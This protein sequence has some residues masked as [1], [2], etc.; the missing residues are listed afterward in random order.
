MFLRFFGCSGSKTTGTLEATMCDDIDENKKVNGV[1]ISPSD[2]EDLYEIDKLKK[3][4]EKYTNY[5]IG[6]TANSLIKRNT[7]PSSD[8]KFKNIVIIPYFVNLNGM[9]PFIQILLCKSI[10]NFPNLYNDT[11]EEKNNTLN[12]ITYNSVKEEND[13][14]EIINKISIFL[15]FHLKWYD[16]NANVDFYKSNYCGYY[17]EDGTGQHNKSDENI[18][19]TIQNQTKT[20][21][22]YFFFNISKLRIDNMFLT[23]NSYLWLITADEI[24]N[25]HKIC[26]YKISNDV[27]TFFLKHQNRRLLKIEQEVNSY[28][29]KKYFE[30][31]IVVYRFN[32]DFNNTFFECSVGA[33]KEKIKDINNKEF[34]IFTDYNTCI[35]Q[36]E[37]M[38]KEKENQ[39]YK[40]IGNKKISNEFFREPSIS[41]IVRYVIFC[42]HEKYRDFKTVEEIR[43]FSYESK[44]KLTT[45]HISAGE[46]KGDVWFVKHYDQQVPLSYHK[47]YMNDELQYIF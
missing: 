18:I 33:S 45:F 8:L 7:L 39:I 24:I 11:E 22:I 17:Y 46:N 2:Y 38:H 13:F 40:T 3:Y 10:K 37:E 21:S 41:G 26:H 30:T 20:S 23:R 47:V 9:Y 42:V 29:K 32:K 28:I 5:L 43:K 34:R 31:P 44:E 12:F 27:K 25:K 19:T 14:N 15:H 4:K 36:L 35:R 1:F 16:K 6:G